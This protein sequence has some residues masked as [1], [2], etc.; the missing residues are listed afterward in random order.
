MAATI[1]GRMKQ[2][3]IVYVDTEQEAKLPFLAMQRLL[4]KAAG[5]VSRDVRDPSQTC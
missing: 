1:A 4:P 5:Y 3:G 2:L